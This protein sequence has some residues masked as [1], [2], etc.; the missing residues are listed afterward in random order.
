MLI[1]YRYWKLFSPVYMTQWVWR[2][3]VENSIFICLKICLLGRKMFVCAGRMSSEGLSSQ[4]DFGRQFTFSGD[5][6]Q[7]KVS[8]NPSRSRTPRYT[9]SELALPWRPRQRGSTRPTWRSSDSSTPGHCA[10]RWQY[11]SVDTSVFSAGS[12]EKL[13]EISVIGGYKWHRSRQSIDYS[14]LGSRALPSWW[15]C[16]GRLC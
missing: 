12:R 2:G 5:W 3:T 4:A 14:Y 1:L 11:K 6:K 8:T 7:S 10:G 9:P 15:E 16:R 13:L